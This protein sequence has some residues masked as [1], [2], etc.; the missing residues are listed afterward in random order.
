MFH[1]H[2]PLGW[3]VLCTQVS[4]NVQPPSQM[5]LR[6]LIFLHTRRVS[7][8]YRCVSSDGRFF[9]QPLFSLSSSGTI[10]YGPS[11]LHQFNFSP[12]TLDFI[13]ITDFEMEFQIYFNYAPELQLIT[14]GNIHFSPYSFDFS[15]R[16]CSFN[17]FGMKV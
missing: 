12:Y 4:E 14:Y 8:K 17:N 10:P 9:V 13:F 7:I 6:H 3:R 2:A 16:F 5:V 11:Y 1:P 15:F